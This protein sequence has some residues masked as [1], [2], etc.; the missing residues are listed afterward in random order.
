M[1][2]NETTIK[3]TFIGIEFTFAQQHG[4]RH[5]RKQKSDF[6]CRILTL[7]R[8][9][10]NVGLHHANRHPLHIL[11]PTWRYMAELN[12]RPTRADFYRWIK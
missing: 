9:T 4:Q 6:L 7:L 12:R 5:A 1:V 3:L 2:T 8:L 11:C 10:L